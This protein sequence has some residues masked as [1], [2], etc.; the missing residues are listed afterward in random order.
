MKEGHLGGDVGEGAT[1]A[2]QVEEE[3]GVPL[4]GVGA[5]AGA[6]GL[7]GGSKVVEPAIT[8]G[9]SVGGAVADGVGGVRACAG[10]VGRKGRRGAVRE[11]MQAG[12]NGEGVIWFEGVEKSFDKWTGPLRMELY[13]CQGSHVCVSSLS[14]HR[15]HKEEE[16]EQQPTALGGRRHALQ[17]YAPREEAP[18]SHQSHGLLLKTHTHT[19]ALTLRPR[20]WHHPP[21]ASKASSWLTVHDAL[22]LRRRYDDEAATGAGCGAAL[23]RPRHSFAEH[24]E[25]VMQGSEEG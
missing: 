19:Q 12:E 21:T 13:T 8:V 7:G 11:W 10:L 15:T 3:G 17:P 20:S 9:V 25:C 14:T 22:A 23:K 6:G 5:A 16:V 1:E 2:V 4:D 24:C 18:S